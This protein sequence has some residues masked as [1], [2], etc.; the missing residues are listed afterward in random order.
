[1]ETDG[2]VQEKKEKTLVAFSPPPADDNE[3]ALDALPDL[4]PSPAGRLDVGGDKTGEHE[5][6]YE[7]PS[8]S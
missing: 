4:T 6:P 8:A 1:M 7:V 5:C 2:S 3:Q